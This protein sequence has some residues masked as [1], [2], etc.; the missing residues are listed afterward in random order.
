VGIT[1]T[2]S[3]GNFIG[4]LRREDFRIFDNGVEQPVTSF[5]SIEEPAQL[6][7]LI[8]SGPAL[9]IMGKRHLQAADAMLGALSPAD[10]VALASYSDDS[11]L[12]LDFTPDKTAA[13]LAL[14]KLNAMAS[15]GHLNLSSSVAATLDWLAF[16]P[17]KKCIVLVSTGIDT[18][19][20]DWQMIQQKLTTSDVRILGIAVSGAFPKPAKWKIPSPEEREAR[21][22]LKEEFAEADRWLYALCASTGGRAYSPKNA[23]EFDRAYAEIAQLVRH[24]YSLEFA[25]PSLDGRL[26]SLTVKVKHSWYHVD[27]R[28]SYLATPPPSY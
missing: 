20:G 4:G 1:V 10:R 13:R 6:V 3:H 15:L 23:K 25:P 26:H 2:G 8:E 21:N 11:R 16:V 19:S 7:L 27:H 12:L 14:Q 22:I 9:L 24:E 28:Q 18:S 17:G 5:L